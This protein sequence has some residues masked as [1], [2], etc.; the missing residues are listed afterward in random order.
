MYKNGGHLTYA[1][2]QV[3]GA[4]ETNQNWHCLIE[5]VQKFHK[6]HLPR[7]TN[8]KPKDIGTK[9]VSDHG[10]IILDNHGE[11]SQFTSR[12]FYDEPSKILFGLGG[13]GF[14]CRVMP[15]SPTK[16]VPGYIT[17]GKVEK[18]MLTWRS[19]V[20]IAIEAR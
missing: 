12:T 5:R 1:L 7:P 4:G 14:S 17:V 6:E 10:P 2:C 19:Q 11:H 18:V 13:S 15:G 16:L 8:P 9:I 3:L 20:S